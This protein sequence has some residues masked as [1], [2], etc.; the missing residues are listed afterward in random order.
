MHRA[1]ASAISHASG[2]RVSF[3]AAT[4]VNELPGFFGA[5]NLVPW[6]D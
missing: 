2:A 6:L 3:W 5:G 1:E 4:V